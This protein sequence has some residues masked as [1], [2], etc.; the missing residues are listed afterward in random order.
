MFQTHFKHLKA[1]QKRQQTT[2]QNIFRFNKGGPWPTHYSQ[3][4]L[5]SVS[6]SLTLYCQDKTEQ[7]SHQTTI[8]D[9][10]H[11]MPT[12][13]RKNKQL[14]IEQIGSLE[15]RHVLTS[16]QWIHSHQAE[17]AYRTHH[18]QLGWAAC[19]ATSRFVD[20]LSLKKR[21]ECHWSSSWFR[22][23]ETYKR[24]SP[25]PGSIKVSPKLFPWCERDHIRIQH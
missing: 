24:L 25:L 20:S 9:T 2:A 23:N 13:I 16:C 7:A 15:T 10:V 6:Y 21:C 11:V 19:L 8:S 1:A 4:T 12:G 5:F 18:D 17:S 14:R 22:L 3:T